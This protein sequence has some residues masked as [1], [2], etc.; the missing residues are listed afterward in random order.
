MTF[1]AIGHHSARAG[2][3]IG[4][5]AGLAAAHGLRPDRMRVN[6]SPAQ[7]S[8]TSRSSGEPSA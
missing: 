3:A 1:E 8:E 7:K 6:G 5:A 4:H 2:R